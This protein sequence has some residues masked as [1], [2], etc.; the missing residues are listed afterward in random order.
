METSF[1]ISDISIGITF[2]GSISYCFLT[3]VEPIFF[4]NLRSERVTS[5]ILKQI[6]DDFKIGKYVKS[7]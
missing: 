4:G 2:S 3:E 7:S 1:K 6:Y 5:E